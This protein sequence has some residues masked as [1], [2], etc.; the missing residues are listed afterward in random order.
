MTNRNYW[1]RFGVETTQ[2]EAVLVV[3]F[4]LVAL[5]FTHFPFYPLHAPQAE[6][7]K[8]SQICVLL[9][10]V[11]CLGDFREISDVVLMIF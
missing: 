7:Q 1:G 2:I 10:Q 5:S 4:G 11:A 8:T 6:P 9:L 3:L